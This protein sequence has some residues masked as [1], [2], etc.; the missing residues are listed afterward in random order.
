MKDSSELISRVLMEMTRP[1]GEM[2]WASVTT[3]ADSPGLPTHTD[4]PAGQTLLIPFQLTS[5]A[6]TCCWALPAATCTIHLTSTLAGSLHAPAAGH[7]EKAARCKD[8]LL[9]CQTDQAWGQPRKRASLCRASSTD[10]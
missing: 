5:P 7:I 4:P 8:P 3:Q 9:V 6:T 2:S 1:K 10:W